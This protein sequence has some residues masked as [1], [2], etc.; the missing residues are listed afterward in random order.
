MAILVKS[1]TADAD[2]NYWGTT[3]ECFADG[4]HLYGRDFFVDVAAEPLTAKCERYFTTDQILADLITDPRD[5]KDLLRFAENHLGSVCFGLDSLNMDWPE[6]WWCN[7]PFDLKAEFIRHAKK[8]QAA[9]RPGMMLL[10]YTKLTD[11]WRSALNK[12]CVIY[13]PDGRYPFYERNG[14]IKKSSPNFDSCFVAF[15]TF[16]INESPIVRFHRGIGSKLAD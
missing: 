11:W 5:T 1:K 14:I 9:G 6:H 12:G 15:P 2:K 10:P 7:P 13:E 16:K 8:Q 4:Q 3:W